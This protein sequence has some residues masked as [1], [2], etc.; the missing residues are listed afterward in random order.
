[1]AKSIFSTLTTHLQK[2]AIIYGKTLQPK[3]LEKEWNKV[4]NFSFKGKDKKG[5]K[6]KATTISIFN[7][8]RVKQRLFGLIQ[9]FK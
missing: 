5:Q 7:V 2:M 6:L 1:M 4:S 9:A 8:K 3:E